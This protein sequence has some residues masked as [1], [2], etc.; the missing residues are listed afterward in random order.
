MANINIGINVNSIRAIRELNSVS[1]AARQFESNLSRVKSGNLDAVGSALARVSA[2]FA[3]LAVATITVAPILKAVDAFADFE[4]QMANVNS[5]LQLNKQEIG[6]L[7]DKIVELN[8]AMNSTQ[9]AANA[10]AAEYQI[11]SAGFTDAAQ[12]LEILQAS[13]TAGTAGLSDTKT[14]ANAIISVMKGYSN[15]NYTA[16]EASDYLFATI[17]KGRTTFEELAPVIGRVVPAA[18]QAGIGMDELGAIMA[19]LTA[20]G[21]QTSEAV[22]ALKKVIIQLQSPTQRSLKF[23]KELGYESGEVAKIMGRDGL[24]AALSDIKSRMET[25]NIE[26]A[27]TKFRTLLG[28]SE[29]LT[30]AMILTGAGAD[31]LAE[32]MERMGNASGAAKNAFEKNTDT[33]NAKI[34]Q[35]GT[36]AERMGIAISKAF[37]ADGATKSFLGILKDQIDLVSYGYENNIGVFNAWGTALSLAGGGVS[38]FIKE[39]KRMIAAITVAASTIAYLGLLAKIALTETAAAMS[40]TAVAAEGLTAGIVASEVATAGWVVTLKAAASAM[41]A[42]ATNPVII[43]LGSIAA[44][45]YYATQRQVEWTKSLEE[46]NKA[47]T[48]YMQGFYKLSADQQTEIRILRDLFVDGEKAK[49][50]AAIESGDITKEKLK[51]IRDTLVSMQK[52]TIDNED[53]VFGL[54]S[55]YGQAVD[56]IDNYANKELK[57]FEEKTKKKNELDKK[58]NLARVASQK[59]INDMIEDLDKRVSDEKIESAQDLS[60]ELLQISNA[61]ALL[62][63]EDTQEMWD[64]GNKI[65]DKFIKQYQKREKDGYQEIERTTRAEVALGERSAKDRLDILKGYYNDR[66]KGVYELKD[67][68]LDVRVQLAE[69]EKQLREAELREIRKSNDNKI[70]NTKDRIDAERNLGKNVTN[71]HIKQIQDLLKIHTL[72]EEQRVNI[73]EEASKLIKAKREE[74]I[75]TF[76]RQKRLETALNKEQI[77]LQKDKIAETEKDV[78]AGVAS[79]STLKQQLR[80]KLKLQEKEIDIEKQKA[81]VKEGITYGETQEIEKKAELELAAARR[82]A[83]DEFIDIMTRVNEKKKEA[84][85]LTSEQLRREKELLDFY[86]GQGQGAI[87]GLD[88]FVQDMNSRFG[89][90]AFSGFGG[91]STAG[92][93]RATA[94]ARNRAL[95]ELGISGN[96]FNGSSGLNGPSPFSGQRPINVGSDGQMLSPMNQGIQRTAQGIDNLVGLWTRAMTG[97]GVVPKSQDF[98]ASYFQHGA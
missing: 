96:P 6:D 40:I 55:K 94:S 53:S 68:E 26:D 88:Q 66:I 50:K 36:S 70:K 83:A 71:E 78:A 91:D 37:G 17:E 64:K 92:G 81:L 74:E 38:N 12:S 51:V 69:E 46:S 54:T 35:L 57:T 84:S 62:M 9:S 2:G 13:I 29:G 59:Q 34:S 52:A 16:Q 44:G 60:D 89:V 93:I 85:N 43:V 28:T 90:S 86:H 65:R 23:F 14:A 19:V 41:W 48:D 45:V 56:I 98:G 42:I 32:A 11:V 97:K 15:E 3:G 7:S 82:A 25:L 87:Q 95:G 77:D 33:I 18:N 20:N 27:D 58:Y 76:Q 1:A 21:L 39:N 47:F 67:L 22:T 24:T 31:D 30:A 63:V 61:A 73:S 79:A 75:T 49:I 8:S 5:L 10:A 4:Q 80:E 72:S